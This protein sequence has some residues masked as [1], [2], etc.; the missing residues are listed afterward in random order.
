MFN[1]GDVVTVRRMSAFPEWYGLIGTIEKCL[2][3]GGFKIRFSEKVPGQ[4]HADPYI[5]N[6]SPG[7][8]DLWVSGTPDWEV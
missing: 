6:L 2:G 7:R 5:L 8:L 1:V 3:W 4:P